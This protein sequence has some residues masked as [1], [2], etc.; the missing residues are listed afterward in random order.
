MAV[1]RWTAGMRVEVSAPAPAREALRGR[2]G[3]VVRLLMRD[4]DEAWV[5]IDGP[6]PELL[7]RFPDGDARTSHVLL[8]RYEVSAHMEA[9]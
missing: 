7:R 9:S 1:R 4:P 6:I 8:R 2:T 3:T 5:A